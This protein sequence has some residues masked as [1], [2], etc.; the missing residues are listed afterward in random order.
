[1]TA[2]ESEAYPATPGPAAQVRRLYRAARVMFHIG[3]GWILAL[4]LGAFHRPRRRVVRRA[5][6]HWL[7][8]T[9]SI[10]GVRVKVTGAPARG[11]V[12]LVSNHVSWLDIPVLGARRELLFLARAEVREWP[13]I[14]PL[15]AAA[16]TLF[17]RGGRGEAGRRRGEIAHQLR[18]GRTVLVFSE[19]TTTD[20]RSVAPFQ[21]RLL[22]AAAEAGVAVQPV[23]V[24]Y[25]T[26]DGR[27]D[28][29][30]AFVGEDDFGRHAW[31]LLSR[32]RIHAH[33]TFHKPLPACALDPARLA[34]E[35]R[36]T[37]AA[38]F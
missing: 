32:R 37:V 15:T 13:I 11:P 1:M 30:V 38:S 10:L 26:A 8:T 34:R 29:S 16:G 36:R 2:L 33:V 19:G 6:R 17:L 12:L 35:T 21:G 31:R 25:G 3:G 7:L 22:G 4:S 9:L 14:G 23:T 27:T 18:R 5:T 20:G 24:R 28:S